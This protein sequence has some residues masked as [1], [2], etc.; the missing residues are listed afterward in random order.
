MLTTPSFSVEITIPFLVVT[1][2]VVFVGLSAVGAKF[3][4]A[5]VPVPDL[6]VKPVLTA[7]FLVSVS[8]SAL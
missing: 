6:N 2:S 1:V 8:V 5:I 7:T 4:G 3:V